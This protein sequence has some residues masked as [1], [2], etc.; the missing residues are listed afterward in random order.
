M[1]T[2]NEYFDGKVKSLV[3][4]N[5]H[6]KATLGV[7]SPGEYEFGTSTVEIMEIVY[8]ELDALL[9]GRTDWI[10]FKAGQDFRVEKS[11]SFKV[12]VSEPVA[13]LCKYM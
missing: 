9:P 3:A 7:I 8:G 4:D 5:K 2:M 10:K 12:M 13:Y 1:V 6:G 11:S